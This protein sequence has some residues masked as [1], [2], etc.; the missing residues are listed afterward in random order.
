MDR[1]A[2]RKSSSS[3]TE[4][5]MENYTASILGVL[6]LCLLSILLAVYSGRSKGAAGALSG[7]VIPADDKSLL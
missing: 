5:S 2:Y 3:L 4:D 1:A 7:P 6:L